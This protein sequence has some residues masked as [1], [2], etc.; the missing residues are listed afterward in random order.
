MFIPRVCSLEDFLHVSPFFEKCM[1]LW[2]DVFVSA[3]SIVVSKTTEKVQ[4]FPKKKAAK[5]SRQHA[6]SSEGHLPPKVV[7][8][9]RWSP[10]IDYL[11]TKVIFPRKLSSS[12]G[13]LPQ[14]VI[15]HQK[16]SS[17]KGHLPPKIVFLRRSSSNK[18]YLPQKV[19]FLP[20]S[21]STRGRLPPKVVF[22]HNTLIDLILKEQ[23]TYRIS[24]SYIA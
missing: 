12:L 1:K 4:T 6:R 23:S 14:K 2:I 15:F 17:T 13:C 7:F 24:A 8:N 22:H 10:S 19:V 5:R 18:G 3:S 20:K 9:R 11:P 16:S 21:S